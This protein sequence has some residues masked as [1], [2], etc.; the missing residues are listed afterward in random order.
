MK[1]FIINAYSILKQNKPNSVK[2]KATKVALVF[3]LMIPFFSNTLNISAIEKYDSYIDEVN[4]KIII[5]E[6][7][8]YVEL[9]PLTRW[10]FENDRGFITVEDLATLPSEVT[11]YMFKVKG[12]T[13]ASA[14][15]AWSVSTNQ[16]W[17][18]VCV[19]KDSEGNTLWCLDASRNFP[20]GNRYT[21]IETV[22]N[23]GLWNLIAKGLADG[24]GYADI[25]VAIY[26]Y[27]A[28][29]S[30][31]SYFVFSAGPVTITVA[32]VKNNSQGGYLVDY[33]HANNYRQRVQ[34][35]TNNLS[36]TYNKSNNTVESQ[37][38]IVNGFNG[39]YSVTGL[40]NG[41]YLIDAGT[42][43]K[44]D[45][46]NNIPQGWTVKVVNPDPS[47]SF[48]G[49]N[50]TVTS[51]DGKQAIGVYYTSHDASKQNL[52][53]YKR[54]DP[55]A[56]ANVILDFE[57]A[58][59]DIEINK[60]DGN[61]KF[62]SGADIT[63]MDAN[64][65]V[66]ATKTTD[67]NGK[68]VFNDLVLGDY[69]YQET[70]APVGHLLDSTIYDIKHD[71]Q[72]STDN[73]VNHAF[74]GRLQI[75]KTANGGT[76]LLDGAVI[77]IYKASDDT[78]V[79]TL[80]SGSHGKGMAISNV[81]EYIDG[82]YYYQEIQAPKGYWLDETKY[83]F[84]IGANNEIIY[85]ALA[86]EQIM[87]KIQARK[88][89]SV[90]KQP[91]EGVKFRIAD[92]DGNFITVKWTVGSEIFE[93]SEWT[94]DANG[95]FTIET[96]IVAGDYLLV[97]TQPLEGYLPMAPIPFTIDENQDYINLELVGNILNVGDIE[98]QQIKGCIEIKKVDKDTGEVIPNTTFELYNS[99]LELIKTVTTG[100]EGTVKICDLVYGDYFIKEIDVPA[101]YIIMDQSL[102]KVSITENG[103]VEYS[104]FENEKEMAIIKIL[105]TN[106]SG[107]LL[108]NVKFEIRD[109]EGTVL[110]TLLTDKNGYVESLPLELYKKYT[111]QEIETVAGHILDETIYEYEF[112][113]KDKE[114]PIIYTQLEVVNYQEPL[115]KT[116]GDITKL[117]VAAGSFASA[118]T[119]VM[120]AKKRKFVKE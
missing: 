44:I 110:Q 55:I 71:N 4:E 21:P 16:S 26:A 65:N 13:T 7:G 73:L 17:I 36:G 93:A 53:R 9:N 74:Q 87:A 70:K 30:G 22:D 57:P 68:V 96:P 63:L 91:L 69:K 35:N 72:N 112:E 75:V 23:Q 62:L 108:A 84:N 31:N 100:D 56:P 61:G 118:I 104:V 3:S 88:I 117:V 34:F 89:D 15:G 105:K 6:E 24:I 99:K 43:K 95:K 94:T 46:P 60:T 38:L 78:L 47:I 10:M 86:N 119:L 80:T 77:G 67:V 107:K 97:E 25:Q 66:I 50:L 39:R 120:I 19:I 29:Q 37:E 103:K 52:G 111:V 79:D 85:K 45:D 59:G 83:P 40:T 27:L 18:G 90:T 106:D 20:N 58:I 81:L 113:F 2:S 28:E 82:G 115:A 102:K 116:G 64:N 109:E 114:T 54:L 101:P 5:S 42:G 92:L 49:V 32:D 51:L 41:L 11:D 12:K 48:N 76:H 33:G 1:K 14:N 98:N 8:Y